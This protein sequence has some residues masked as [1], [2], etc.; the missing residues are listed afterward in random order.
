MNFAR[1]MVCALGVTAW[2]LALSPA[3]AVPLYRIQ[4]LPD[5]GQ[6]SFAHAAAT[7]GG[8][9]VAVGDVNGDDPVGALWVQVKNRWQLRLLTDAGHGGSARIISDQATPELLIGGTVQ[10]ENGVDH[11]ALWRLRRSQRGGWTEALRVLDSTAGVRSEVVGVVGGNTNRLLVVGNREVTQGSGVYHTIIWELLPN[12]TLETTP[13]PSPGGLNARAV[14]GGVV[15]PNGSFRIPGN[16]QFPGSPLEEACE[17]RGPEL[18]SLMALLLPAVGSGVES[19]QVL[20]VDP[21]LRYAV[22]RQ[23]SQSGITAAAWATS[24][25]SVGDWTPVP[26]PG[27]AGSSGQLFSVN[28]SGRALGVW[29]DTDLAYVQRIHVPSDE[30]RPLL[31]NSLC[32]NETILGTFRQRPGAAV[33]FNDVLVSSISERGI[34]TA[35]GVGGGP[36]RTATLLV[37]RGVDAADYVAVSEGEAITDVLEPALFYIDDI[38]IGIEAPSPDDWLSLKLNLDMANA[39]SRNLTLTVAARVDGPRRDGAREV[40]CLWS[41]TQDRY[42]EIN[43]AVLRGGRRQ[44]LRHRLPANLAEFLSPHGD[45]HM[46]LR[47]NGAGFPHTG[48]GYSVQ[49][50]SVNLTGK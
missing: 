28:S 14:G 20:G 7:V 3:A 32:T 43:S 42:I 33:V 2:C 50:D 22:G 13:L 6:G 34:I 10:D 17:W 5:G 15:L 40:L 11:A 44:T 25:P 48:P 29:D 31:L 8:L 39:P 26:L 41:F 1:F 37:P 18:E 9:S 49:V 12:G 23:Q 36:H 45:L 47:W 24:P 27:Q 4:A 16:A 35:G 38:I 21:L 30:L 46:S 19:Q